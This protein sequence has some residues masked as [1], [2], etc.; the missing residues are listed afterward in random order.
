MNAVRALLRIAGFGA[1]GLVLLAIGIGI[2]TPDEPDRG[3]L[4]LDPHVPVQIPLDEASR[5]VGGACWFTDPATGQLTA[6][7]LPEGEIIEKAS[8]SPW[9]DEQGRRRLIG[10]WHRYL[11]D[12]GGSVSRDFGMALFSYPDGRCLEVLPMNL[13]PTGPPCWAP[14][15]G[16]EVLFPAADGHLYALELG[17]EGAKEPL[18]LTIGQRVPWDGDV[19]IKDLSW[20]ADPRFG[21]RLFASVRFRADVDYRYS[22]AELWW[23]R[24]SDDHLQIIEAGRIAVPGDADVEEQ[25]PQVSVGGDDRMRLAFLTDR[26]QRGRLSLAVADLSFG[27]EDGASEVGRPIVLA[28]DCF[29]TRPAFSDD[30]TTLT[31]VARNGSSHGLHP[32]RVALPIDHEI[33]PTQYAAHHHGD[34]PSL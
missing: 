9:R 26:D 7:P 27:P 15:D 32:A 33:A 8:L 17:G 16:E 12:E 19:Q 24:L 1:T 13:I 28:D 2:A 34:V 29:A 31:Y 18:A 11:G 3:G 30:G 10:R 23:L 20:P 22:D 14:F 5:R 21:G 25:F 4:T 6:M